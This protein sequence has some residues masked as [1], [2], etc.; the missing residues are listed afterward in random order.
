MKKG[1]LLVL[2][3]ISFNSYSQ[4]L[5]ESEIRRVNYLGI[6]T[7]LYDLNN[8]N[9]QMDFSKILKLNRQKKTSSTFGVVLGFVSVLT[10]TVGIIA[11]STNWD[12]ELLESVMQSVGG[13]SLGV[14][15]VSGGFS[16]KLFD[17]SKKRK[18]ERDKLIDSYQ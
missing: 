18:K 12:D 6:E 1:A 5:K 13:V 7:S 3:L 4:S 9:I 10:S 16:I 17:T 2:I 8:S 11:L 15:V 14:G